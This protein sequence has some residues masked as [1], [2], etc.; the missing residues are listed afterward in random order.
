MKTTNRRSA[1]PDYA[2]QAGEGRWKV[3][4][5]IQPGAKQDAAVGLY[6]GRLKLR[7]RAPA[8]DNKANKAAVAFLASLLGLK[9]SQVRLEAGHASRGKTIIVES[10]NPPDWPDVAAMD[11][12]QP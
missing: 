4:C 5:W 11:G 10:Q 8:V 3:R 12:D 2:D 9:K 7:L 6:Q 1:C